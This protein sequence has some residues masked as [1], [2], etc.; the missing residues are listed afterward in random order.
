MGQGRTMDIQAPQSGTTT[1]STNTG[2]GSGP[3]SNPYIAVMV[4]EG[5]R[6]GKNY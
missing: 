3:L 1:A 4:N 6:G 2:Q 5:S